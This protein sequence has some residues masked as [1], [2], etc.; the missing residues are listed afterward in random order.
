M[1]EVRELTKE[2]GDERVLDRLSFT[3]HPGEVT[4]LLGPSGSGKSV[5]MRIVLGTES[6]TAGTVL[7]N[8]RSPNSTTRCTVAAMVGDHELDG[9]LTVAD[10]LNHLAVGYGV[11][12]RRVAEV[13]AET[14]L[15]PVA[16]KF[17]GCLST[18]V[19]QR[20]RIAGVLLS[21]AGVLLFDSPMTG[22]DPGRVRWAREQMHSLARAG[23]TVLVSGS[24]VGEMMLNARRVF[25][26]RV[27][28]PVVEASVHELADHFAGDVFV[29]SPRRGALLRVLSRMGATALPEPGGGLAVT[30]MEAWQI[31]SAAAALFIPIQELTP[32]VGT[33]EDSNWNEGAHTP[34]RQ[35]R[36]TRSTIPTA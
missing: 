21:D 28:E 16:G 26:L 3:A 19:R 2:Y 22:L 25:V 4:G 13:L 14:E 20:L 31:A 9:G 29:R 17:I 36:E 5:A 18:G 32:R 30:G 24:D 11:S 8:G 12:R 27:G 6:P 7:V 1:I 23:R 34:K 35:R 33:F 10:H 15:S